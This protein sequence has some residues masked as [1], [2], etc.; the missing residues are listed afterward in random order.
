MAC[1]RRIQGTADV[2]AWP[3]RRLHESVQ[4]YRILFYRLIFGKASGYGV[5]R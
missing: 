3:V 5:L 2:V 4:G 1:A